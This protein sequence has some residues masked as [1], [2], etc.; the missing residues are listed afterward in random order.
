MCPK[1]ESGTNNGNNGSFIVTVKGKKE[2]Y[3]SR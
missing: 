1:L 2:R 3:R